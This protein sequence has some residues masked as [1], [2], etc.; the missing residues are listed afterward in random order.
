MRE[1]LATLFEVVADERAE[2]TAIIQGDVRRT[3][4]ELDD[5]AA[6]LAR[7][8][9]GRG[10][11]H[12]SRVA[13]ALYNGPE[14]VETLLAVLKLRAAPVNV[15]YRYRS[16]EIAELL[17][18]SGA[19]VIV[20]DAALS[21]DVADAVRD[22]PIVRLGAADGPDPLAGRADDYAAAIAAASPLLREPRSGDDEW[23]MF[24]GGTTG[25]PKGVRN[26]QTEL[27]G[28][29]A[30]N[31]YGVRG[32]PRPADLDELR[33]VTRR[34][35][36]GPGRLVTLVAPPLIHATG[37]YTALGTLLAAGTV[38]FARSRTYDPRELA[39]LVDRHEVTNLCLVG[40]VFAAPFADVLDAAAAAGRPYRLSALREIRSVGVTW[41]PG[42]KR[43]LL[44]HADVRLVDVIAASEGGPFASSVT[45]RSGGAITSTF[46]L[47]PGAR[48]ID[49]DDRD[50]RPGEVGRLAAPCADDAAY[51]GDPAR[52]AATF[53]LI[54]GVRH[55]VPGDLATIRED[56]SLVL[57][58]RQGRVINTGGEKVYAEEVEQAIAAHPEVGDVVVVGVPDPRWGHRITAVVSVTPGAAPTPSDIQSAVT[59]RLAGYK[60]PRTVVFVPR[61]PRTPAGK[62]DLRQA[63]ILAEGDPQP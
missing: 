25:R 33:A 15:N 62:L 4:R 14:Y 23:L 43:R 27:F 34:L 19:T 31:G 13:M 38:V 26:R 58:G 30:G 63:R 18:G 5:R 50:V 17:T 39:V 6:R 54:D 59:S 56:G 55:T 28:I 12:G 10:V 40:D 36:D 45:T 47:L 24:T 32:V 61:V 35:S 22:S 20:A 46:E 60:K 53:R 3:W 2:R 41:S 16:R 9:R 29:A 51:L 48:V 57:L 11:R 37:L 52:S 42:V 21:T 44:D 49:A 7:H 1:N 8:L